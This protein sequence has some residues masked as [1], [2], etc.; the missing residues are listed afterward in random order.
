MN[1]MLSPCLTEGFSHNLS[2]TDSLVAFARRRFMIEL[3]GM[4]FTTGGKVL[5]DNGRIRRGYVRSI[6]F[7]GLY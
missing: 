3:F 4:M 1:G 5:E 2:P 7:P 6:L